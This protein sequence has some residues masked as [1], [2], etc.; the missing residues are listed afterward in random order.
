M[1]GRKLIIDADPGVGDAI[2]IALALSDPEIEIVGL[3]ATAG[4]VSGRQA[5]CNLQ[6][7]LSIVDPALW[8][9]VGFSDGPH[10]L[11]PSNRGLLLPAG[12]HGLGDCQP[13]EAPLHQPT[14]SVKVMVELVKQ[15]PGELTL[16]TLGPL[17]NVHLAMERYPEFLTNLKE[18]VTLAG[19]VAEGG[20]VSAAAEFNVYANP[21][22]AHVVF[23]FPTM[24]KLLP[25]DV[26]R[27]MV[28]SFDQYNRLP[29][30]SYTRLGRVLEWLFP[31]GLRESRRE[32][33]IEGMAVP[34]IMALAAVARP[35]LFET[36]PMS[37]QVELSGELTRGATVFDRRFLRQRQSNV[38]VLIA[39]DLQGVFDYVAELLALVQP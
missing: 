4:V 30:S 36:Q 10:S 8:P 33:G 28:M 3:T 13:V 38:D 31:F 34:E 16:L 26:A 11:L 39:V 27:K 6:T 21:E 23:N 20:D 17:T 35:T 5:S 2:A 22:A 19:A 29:V 37:M 24:P 32:F 9:R 15:H 14:D 7:V 1:I 18:V 25:I 12:K